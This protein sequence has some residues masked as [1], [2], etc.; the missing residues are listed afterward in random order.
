MENKKIDE[1][2]NYKLVNLKQDLMLSLSGRDLEFALDQVKLELS[3]ELNEITRNLS[4][5]RFNYQ[6]SSITI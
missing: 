4:L 5:S 1:A 3:R 6:M 2:L